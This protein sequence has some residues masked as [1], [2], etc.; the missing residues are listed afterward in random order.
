MLD[1]GTG[2]GAIAVTLA[3]EL[4]RVTV[5]AVDISRAALAVA[6]ENAHRIGVADRVRFCRADGYSALKRGDRFDVVVSNPPYVSEKEWDSLPR[7]VRGYEPAQALLAG[8][9]GLSMIRTLVANAGEYLKPGGGLWLEIGET[10]G[11]A[12]RRLPCGP[13]RFAGVEKDLAGRDRVARWI[14]PADAKR[15]AP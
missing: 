11:N 3:A 8:P 15:R 10:Q 2:C 13:L 5:L 12:V 9:D 1:V 6:R 14:L 4:P 7:E